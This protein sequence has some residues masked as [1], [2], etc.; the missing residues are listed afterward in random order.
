MGMVRQRRGR[1]RRP[2]FSFHTRQ[3]LFLTPTPFPNPQ[4]PLVV[5][6]IPL[7]LSLFHNHFR[8]GSATQ[9]WSHSHLTWRRLSHEDFYI[10]LTHLRLG[11]TERQCTLGEIEAAQPLGLADAEQARGWQR[12]LSPKLGSHSVPEAGVSGILPQTAILGPA[13]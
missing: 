3:S 6:P 10:I 13:Y 4:A 5:T 7:R 1:D 12:R 11:P 9:S 2:H 8:E